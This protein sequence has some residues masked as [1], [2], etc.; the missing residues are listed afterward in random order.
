MYGLQ[1][2]LSLL[3]CEAY[4][5]YPFYQQML[6]VWPLRWG[7]ASYLHDGIWGMMQVQ[8]GL[9]AQQAVWMAVMMRDRRKKA[10]V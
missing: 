3:V 4:P 10:Q 9:Q 6:G 5:L 7:Y 1:Q 2:W 8:I